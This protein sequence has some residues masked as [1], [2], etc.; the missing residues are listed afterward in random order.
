MKPAEEKVK[1]S[2][3][4]DVFANE[5]KARLF[6]KASTRKTGWDDPARNDAIHQALLDTVKLIG[7]P[8]LRAVD[9]ANYAMFLWWQ[10]WGRD[11]G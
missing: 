4:V 8:P 1:L 7:R 5:M 2:H 3:A 10:E 6:E 11:A 9:V